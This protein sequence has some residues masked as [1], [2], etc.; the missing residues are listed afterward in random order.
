MDHESLRIELSDTRGGET[1]ELIAGVRRFNEETAGRGEARALVVTVRDADGRLL[2]G[3]SGRTIY[4]HFLIEVLWVDP[5]HR[6]AGLGTR[7]MRLAETEA[8]T[9]GCVAAQVDTLSFQAPDFYRR[10]GFRQIGLIEDFPAGHQRHFL[11]KPYP[12]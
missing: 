11:F 12:A 9:R 1:D 6:H 4:R 3:V 2:A 10:L 7:V 8:R 5:A